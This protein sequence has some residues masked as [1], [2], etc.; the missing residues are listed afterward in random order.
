MAKA[1]VELS[2]MYARGRGVPKDLAKAYFWMK[3]AAPRF[4]PGEAR[5]NAIADLA[6]IEEGMTATQA[7]EALRLA[8]EWEPKGEGARGGKKG[9]PPLD[10][11]MP[12]SDPNGNP[13]A[14]VIEMGR[15][16]SESAKS[17]IPPITEDG[18]SSDTGRRFKGSWIVV[19]ILGLLTIASV[20][21]IPSDPTAS[22]ISLC[23][24][25]GILAVYVLRKI[26]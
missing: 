8:R 9:I 7:V 12:H 4:P 5:D 2:I 21:G 23:L 20:V 11:H 3:L 10:H 18:D 6:Q 26:R 22:A 19:S 16:S 15:R 25:G 1:Q 14:P 24:W 17:Q 13:D